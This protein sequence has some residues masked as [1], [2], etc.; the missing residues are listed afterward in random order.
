[1][2]SAAVGEL[3]QFFGVVRGS[4][5][6]AIQTPTHVHDLWVSGNFNIGH[7]PMTPLAVQ[8]GRNVRAMGEMDKVRHLGDWHPGNFPVIQNIIFELGQP[9]AGISLGDLLMASPAF[10]ERRQSRRGS[11]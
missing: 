9:W 6:V 2:T 10:C 11:A 1:M 7:I 4:L 5:F 8:A 3:G